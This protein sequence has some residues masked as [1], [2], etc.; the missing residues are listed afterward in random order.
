VFSASGSTE[1]NLVLTR[2]ATARL[3]SSVT[4][5]A[6]RGAATLGLEV[7]MLLS[8]DWKGERGAS[9]VCLNAAED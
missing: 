7:G 3:A 9:A 8:A 1:L 6:G 4:W 2:E 5:A